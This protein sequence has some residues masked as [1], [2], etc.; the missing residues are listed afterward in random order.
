[1]KM[2]LKS[3]ELTDFKG[4]KHSKVEF[5]GNSKISGDNGTGKT[6]LAVAWLWLM[7]DVNYELKSNPNIRPNGQEESL[8]T[9]A[10]VI[11]VDGKEITLMKQQKCKKSKPDANGVQKI[12]LTNNY[13]INSVPKTQRDFDAYLKDLEIDTDKFLCLSHP[14]L[15]MT[16][17]QDAMRKT[18]FGMATDTASDYDIAASDARLKDLAELLT[19]YSADEV[20]AMN[21]ATIKKINDE[22]GNDG[23]AIQNQIIGLEHAKVTYDTAELELHKSELQREIATEE[24]KLKQPDSERKKLEQEKFELQFEIN[25][26]KTEMNDAL[27]RQRRELQSK[28]DDLKSAIAKIDRSIDEDAAVKKSASDMIS[29]YEK[30]L[31]DAKTDYT[32]KSAEKYSGSDIC[33]TCGQKLPDEMIENAK[34]IFENTKKQALEEISR[35]GN[36]AKIMQDKW[37]KK[38]DQYTFNIEAN[39]DAK[40]DLDAQ[41]A[42]IVSEFEKLPSEPDYST[43]DMYTELIAKDT[44]LVNRIAALPEEPDNSDVAAKIVDLKKQYEEVSGKIGAVY[45]N[46]DIDAQISALRDKQRQYEQEKANAER[47]LDM[48]NSLSKLK[49][50]RLTDEINKHFSIVRWKLFDYQKNG[51][52]KEVCIPVIDGYEFKDSTNRGRDLKAKLDIVYSLQNYYKQWFP[53]FFDDSDLLATMYYNDNTQLIYTE[54]VPGQELKIESEE[55]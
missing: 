15:F 13:E 10:A 14:D 7:A 33:P 35:R 12:A 40:K 50:E 3:L 55:K 41:Y 39:Q 47:I 46:N 17:K 21:K 1:M 52:Y 11:D 9:V 32:S 27:T 8:P 23:K 6:T 25:G 24:L 36:N 54:V 29:A 31:A 30:Q 44:D 20:Q 51:E 49:N 38:I 42:G 16:Q 45:H 53:V 26:V 22:C 37:K 19:Q 34:E 43:N 4:T 18:L 48:L 28:A 5:T 2:T